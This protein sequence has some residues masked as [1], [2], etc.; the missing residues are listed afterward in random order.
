MK[1]IIQVFGPTLAYLALI[2]MLCASGLNLA[3]IDI[4][5]DQPPVEFHIRLF[6]W[7]GLLLTNL[8]CTILVAWHAGAKLFTLVRKER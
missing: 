4:Q 2:L 6:G 1:D 5:W 8:L 3:L 7:N